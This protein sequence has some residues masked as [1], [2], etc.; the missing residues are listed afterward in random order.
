VQGVEAGWVRSKVGEGQTAEGGGGRG[1]PV[2]GRNTEGVLGGAGE[3]VDAVLSEWGE[4]EGPE[5]GGWGEGGGGCAAHWGTGVG[6]AHGPHAFLWGGAGGA[7]CEEVR[8]R[9]HPYFLQ[10][11]S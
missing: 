7:F 4:G 11:K 10:A 8:P 9:V 1:S 6:P 3:E 2:L 5:G